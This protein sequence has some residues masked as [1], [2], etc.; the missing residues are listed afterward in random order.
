MWKISPFAHGFF[1]A[2]WTP[3]GNVYIW[4][5]YPMYAKVNDNVVMFR[6]W[7]VMC[8]L[9]YE[10]LPLRRGFIN[11]FDKSKQNGF[12]PGPCQ[13]NINEVGSVSRCH[14][15]LFLADF[16]HLKTSVRPPP[17]AQN[18]HYSFCSSAF[19]ACIPEDFILAHNLIILGTIVH[20]KRFYF[21][22]QLRSLLCAFAMEKN[23]EGIIEVS[24]Y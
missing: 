20:Q 11:W 14:I 13:G 15:T 4:Y 21:G 8:L 18:M 12:I 16:S 19:Y 9:Q 2:F 7:N 22:R 5:E 23:R 6:I 10:V 17:T 3:S 24:R 1:F